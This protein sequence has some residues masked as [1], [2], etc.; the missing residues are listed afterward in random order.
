MRKLILSIMVV[1]LFSIGSYAASI[2]TTT[3]KPC[4]STEALSKTTTPKGVCPQYNFWG[5]Y[6]DKDCDCVP[7][8]KDQCPMDKE[9]YNGIDD[10]DG[11]P[12]ELIRMVV[13]DKKSMTRDSD[14]D[15]I[16]DDKDACPFKAGVAGNKGCPLYVKKIH[17]YPAIISYSPEAK[18]Y[19]I[20]LNSF[21][22][23]RLAVKEIRNIRRHMK[24]GICLKRVK[25]NGKTWFR[26]YVG[27]FKSYRRAKYMLRKVHRRFRYIS[28]DRKRIVKGDKLYR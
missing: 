19:F 21:K 18:K 22:T 25:I 3:Q 14:N 28:Y 17:Y 7:D 16:T 23:F 15:G 27:P 13:I 26:T 9:N 10:N 4:C 5:C 20:R 8:A 24:V 1:L 11:C 6:K 2:I 12:E